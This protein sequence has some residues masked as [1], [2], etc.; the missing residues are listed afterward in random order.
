M[1]VGDRVWVISRECEGTITEVIS[2]GKAYRVKWKEFNSPIHHHS[3]SYVDLVDETG[4][5]PIAQKRR[6]EI[7]GELGI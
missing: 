5:I 3:Y 2:P 7:L 6:E 1:E 4:I